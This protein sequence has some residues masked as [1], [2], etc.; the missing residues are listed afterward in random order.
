MFTGDVEVILNFRLYERT[1]IQRSFCRSD[2]ILFILII[3]LL[4][5]SCQGL[6]VAYFVLY[7]LAAFDDFYYR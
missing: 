7:L 1:L 3:A 5:Q 4:T 6:L 2:F